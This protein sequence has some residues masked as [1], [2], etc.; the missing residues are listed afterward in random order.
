M[1]YSS[2]FHELLGLEPGALEPTLDAWTQYMTINS[3]AQFEAD[4]ERHRL[5]GADRFEHQLEIERLDG[6]RHWMLCRAALVR[7]NHTGEATRVVGS[8]ADITDLKQAQEQLR[9]MTLTDDLTGLSNRKAFTE[10]VRQAVKRK[11]FIDGP[12]PVVLYFDFDRF[13]A[14]ND[15]L[16]HSVGDELLKSIAERLRNCLPRPVT[17]ARLGGDEFAVLLPRT[18]EPE[19]RATTTHLLAELARPHTLQGHEVVSTASIGVVVVEPSYVDAGIVLRDAD[20]AMYAAKTAGRSQACYFDCAMRDQTLDRL[21]IESALRQSVLSEQLHLMYQPIINLETGQATGVEAL[22]RWTHPILGDVPRDRFLPIAE[23]TGEIVRF[24]GWAIEQAIQQ[25]AQW[26][27]LHTG[28]PLVMHINI[29]KRQLLQARCRQ[30]LQQLAEAFPMQIHRVILEVTETSVMDT[31]SDVLSILK[32]IRGMGYRVAMD[33]FGTGHSSLSSL[34][35]FPIDALKIDSSFLPEGTGRR[36]FMAVLASIITLAQNLGLD[37]IAE[38]IETREQVATLQSIECGYA[39]G[40]YF[41]E[42]M[43]AVLAWQLLSDE[44]QTVGLHAA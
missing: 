1:H 4:F 5:T 38:G 2:T 28:E 20:T 32:L 15:S 3:R 41:A 29:S 9:A 10:Q 16:G 39:Q 30:H 34:H 8:L 7:E 13:K 12:L 43:T 26:D 18:T 17:I 24:G 33:D 14:V 40:Y 22:L 44:M 37:V 23:E 25:L 11:R 36:E 19:L 27:E 35:L 6:T 31:R 42:P 21:E